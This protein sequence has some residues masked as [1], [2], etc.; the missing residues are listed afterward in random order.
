MKYELVLECVKSSIQL[1]TDWCFFSGDSEGYIKAWDIM[2]F[3]LD[4]AQQEE[5]TK[6]PGYAKYKQQK[7]SK[8]IFID[9][10]FR[11]FTKMASRRL[12]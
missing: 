6:Q 12:R 2:T 10:D 3:C 4:K 9:D 5:L 11:R 7:Y 1:N 8:F